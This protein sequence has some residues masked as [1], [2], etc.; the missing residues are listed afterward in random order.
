M[1]KDP[2]Y[3][4]NAIE[5]LDNSHNSI[6][7]NLKVVMAGEAGVGKSAMIKSEK[8]F[9]SVY[10]ST[11]CFEHSWRDFKVNEKIIRMQIWDTSGQELYRSLINKFFNEA[12]VV[13]I[14]FALDDVE[15]F[16]KCKMW[17][18][19]I[20]SFADDETILYLVGNKSDSENRNVSKEQ[21]DS[22]MNSNNIKS[23][24]ECSAKN[25][26]SVNELFKDVIMNGYNKFILPKLN[27]VESY[28]RE[29]TRNKVEDAINLKGENTRGYCNKDCL[30][31]GY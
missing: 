30:C 21:I 14:V 9:E 28:S 6:D 13:I 16:N 20:K 23:Y 2:I 5:S 25:S 3:S 27:Q 1:K 15:S 7:F 31:F 17:V 22:F 19:E 29:S 18:N 11:I 26:E 10:M 12:S 4:S 24:K 8:G